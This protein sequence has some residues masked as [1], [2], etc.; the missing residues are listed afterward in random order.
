MKNFILAFIFFLGWFVFGTWIY[1]CHIKGLCV[2][3][4]ADKTSS[5]VTADT[6][7][8]AEKK[9]IFSPQL[10]KD[11]AITA[12]TDS[13]L[14]FGKALNLEKRVFDF[15]NDNQDQELYITGLHNHGEKNSLGEARAKR[16]KVRF[17]TYGINPDRISVTS[18]RKDFKFDNNNRYRGGIRME[19]REL[20]EDRNA[21]IEEGISNKILYSNFGSEK[22]QPD[23]TLQAYARE[24][25][26]YLDKYPDKNILV[27]GHTDNVGTDEANNWVGL[28]RAKSV[29]D[30]L[31]SAGIPESQIEALSE[32]SH[33]PL[34]SNSTIEGRRKNRRIEIK[35]N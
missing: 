26:R 28:Q 8:D 14:F 34:E 19:Y 27:T 12:G 29:M 11:I 20:T 21:S 24:L 23:N 3:T 16:A 1:S 13:V 35:V 31:V 9:L 4:A 25:K 17:T 33:Q 2:D 18:A 30:Y 10:L 7:S 22:F 32:G 6:L 5:P 15:L